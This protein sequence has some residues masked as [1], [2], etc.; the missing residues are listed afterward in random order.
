MRMPDSSV[1]STL[2]TVRKIADLPIGLTITV[3]A[4]LN[5]AT[6]GQIE[7]STG[8]ATTDDEL[9][10]SEI[11]DEVSELGCVRDDRD[12]VSLSPHDNVKRA[13]TTRATA[14]A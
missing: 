9:A 3:S 7:F 13:M 2:T 11:A 5:G 14:C 4:T 12:A 1:N 8:C 6:V 10:V